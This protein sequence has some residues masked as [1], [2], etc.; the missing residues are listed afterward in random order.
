MRAV[1]Y[2]A[3]IG[4]VALV[5][6][7]MHALWAQADGPLSMGEREVAV[8]APADGDP[9]FSVA[10][11]QLVNSGRSKL[12]IT[13]VTLVDAVDVEVLEVLL[14][15]R[16]A[17]EGLVGRGVGWP[18]RDGQRLRRWDERVPAVGAVV[19][20]DDNWVLVA[21]LRRTSPTASYDGIR[22]EYRAS[23]GRKYQELHRTRVVFR[24]SEGC[25]D[26]PDW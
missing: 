11:R 12:T 23:W 9:D 14:V 15:P 21:G 8:C 3:L 10:D 19:A 1:R 25:E 6:V 13:D 2:V 26:D 7:S 24:P 5:L 16:A 17:G 4:V 20:P 22:V 18:P